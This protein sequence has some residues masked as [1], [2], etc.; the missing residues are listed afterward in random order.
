MRKLPTVFISEPIHEVGIAMLKGKVN[1][2]V[3]PNTRRETAFQLLPEA[4]VAILRA[5]TRFDKEMIGKG[6]RLR[7]IVRTGIGV[8]NVDLRSA[9]ERGIFVCNTPGTNTD[10]VAEHVAAMVLALSKQVIFMDEAVRTQRWQERFSPDQRD[11]QNKKIGIVGLG[12]TGRAAARLC[13]ALGMEVLA[14]DPFLKFGDEAIPMTGDLNDLFRESDFISL[15]CPSTPLT[16]RFIGSAYLGLM[17]KEAFLINASR[18]D[19]VD[20]A[21]LI[22]VLEEKKIAG[23]ALD[24][25]DNEP[26][27]KDHPFLQMSNVILSPHVAGSTRES[28]ERI[29]VA[30][31]S[32][33][34]DTLNGKVPQHICNLEYLPA[35]HKE[36]FLHDQHLHSTRL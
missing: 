11:I 32:A 34:L 29:A 36:K 8:D 33:A 25:F 5:T 3:A 27:N 24:V 31:V 10:T 13:K 19:L 7:A 2:V 15:H 23:A 17:K 30:A 14:Y 18:G 22:K 16:H 9:G 28:N 4:D 21:A 1:I 26:P 35:D 6:T 20:E 12:K